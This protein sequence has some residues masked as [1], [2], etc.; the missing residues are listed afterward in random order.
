MTSVGVGKITVD[1]I[2][3]SWVRF[4]PGP[5]SHRGQKK[6][7]FTS[8]SCGSLITFS[9]ANAQWVFHGVHIALIKHV[10][11]FT[12]RV[13]LTMPCTCTSLPLNLYTSVF[14]GG[15]GFELEQKFWR[16]NEF[17]KKRHG[18]ADLHTPI[19]PTPGDD[20]LFEYD[21]DS[22][23]DSDGFVVEKDGAIRDM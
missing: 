19:H 7:F 8:G 20:Q 4:L 9:R 17:G 22:D 21:D 10:A 16:I 1:L 5:Y 11:F 15:C 2:R 13:K 23:N 18:S 12:I 3:K 14:G 6:F